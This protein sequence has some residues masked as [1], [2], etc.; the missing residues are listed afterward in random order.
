MVGGLC[1]TSVPCCVFLVLLLHTLKI[2]KSLSDLFS[3]LIELSHIKELV[4]S[5]SSEL[6]QAGIASSSFQKG[7]VKSAEYR[8]ASGTGLGVAQGSQDTGK[9][10]PWNPSS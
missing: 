10:Q 7:L 2:C 9:E 6:C 5:R 4:S 8:S 3:Y 1:K